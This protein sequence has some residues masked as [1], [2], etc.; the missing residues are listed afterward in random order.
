RSDLVREVSRNFLAW[1]L[2]YGSARV[3]HGFIRRRPVRRAYLDKNPGFAVVAVIALALGI[4]VNATV[5]TITNAVLFKGQP[6]DRNDRIV[7]MG[8][9]NANRN[10]QQAGVSCPDFRDW[11]AAAK[12]FSGLAGIQGARLNIADADNPPEQF[13]GP[14]VTANL[15]QVI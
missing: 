12:S 3:A 1:Y 13:I 2:V 14:R 6:F 11:R 15:F 10:N 4:G 9:R 5:F 8:T 7:Y